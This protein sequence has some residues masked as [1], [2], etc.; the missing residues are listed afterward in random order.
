VCLTL[1]V[2]KLRELVYNTPALR[3]N[4]VTYREAA[5]DKFVG[6][7]LD[8]GLAAHERNALRRPNPRTPVARRRSCPRSPRWSSRS[9]GRS[10][11]R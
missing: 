9:S 1:D 3:I 5:Q 11:V 8:R 10:A 7:I 6:D 4:P 2:R